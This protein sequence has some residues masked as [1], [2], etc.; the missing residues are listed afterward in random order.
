MIITHQHMKRFLY[1]SKGGRRFAERHDLDWADFVKNGIDHEALL[2]TDDA[3]A[4]YIVNK[5]LQYYGQPQV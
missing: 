3:M 2:A 4:T 1:C 5:V